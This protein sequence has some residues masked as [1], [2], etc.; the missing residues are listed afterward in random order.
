MPASEGAALGACSERDV[1]VV[2]GPDGPRFTANRSRQREPH[3]HPR[4][5]PAGRN[6]VVPNACAKSSESV[7]DRREGAGAWFLAWR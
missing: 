2:D 3:S 7:R 5:V 4:R 6:G 1:A